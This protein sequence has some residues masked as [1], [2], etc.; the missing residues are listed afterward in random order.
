MP[1]FIR[2]DAERLCIP[3]KILE[4][5]E[6]DALAV[7]TQEDAERLSEQWQRIM[8]SRYAKLIEAE[9]SAQRGIS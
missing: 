3:G 9:D 2:S 1:D 4:D 6:W 8:P 5:R 7:V